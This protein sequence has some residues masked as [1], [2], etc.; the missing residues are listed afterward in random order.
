M[1]T[2]DSEESAKQRE[3]LAT[4]RRTLEVDALKELWAKVWRSSHG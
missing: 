1:P 2:A 3:L 4:Y